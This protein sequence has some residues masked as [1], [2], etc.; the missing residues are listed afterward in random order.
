M[1][2]S[3]QWQVGHCSLSDPRVPMV[4]I[5]LSKVDIRVQLTEFMNMR[6]EPNRGALFTMLAL[7]FSKVGNQVWSYWNAPANFFSLLYN[8]PLNV[9]SMHVL[10]LQNMKFSHGPYGWEG[11]ECLQ[12]NTIP[13]EIWQG[14]YRTPWRRELLTLVLTL[15]YCKRQPSPIHDTNLELQINWWKMQKL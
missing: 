1:L 3:S 14:L 8:S 2:L 6:C 10:A 15:I 4:Q 9:Q 13:L 7:T 12:C 11:I 5:P